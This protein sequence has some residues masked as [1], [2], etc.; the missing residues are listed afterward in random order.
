MVYS[1]LYNKS[2]D[3]YIYIAC[4]QNQKPNTVAYLIEFVKMGI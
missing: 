3:I 4:N 1:E 2:I